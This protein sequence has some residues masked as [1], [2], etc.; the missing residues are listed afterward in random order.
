M[1]KT[2]FTGLLFF[3]LCG[4]QELQAQYDS[5]FIKSYS[6]RFIIKPIF[7]VR[8]AEIGLNGKFDNEFQNVKYFPNGNSYY[9]LGVNLFGVNLEFSTKFPSGLQ[10]SIENYGETNSLDFRANIY[11]QKIGIN[12]AFQMYEGFY[13]HN[14]ENHF[15]SWQPTDPHPNKRAKPPEGYE[16]VRQNER[17]LSHL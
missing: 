17:D 2:F 14:P 7:S 13:L 16:S 10:R 4:M 6:D 1:K 3:V 9:G 5:S 11:T 8:T 15:P 12:F